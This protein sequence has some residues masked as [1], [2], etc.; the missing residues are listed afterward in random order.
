MADVTEETLPRCS[1]CGVEYEW[2]G[3][4]L[5]GSGCDMR[6]PLARIYI[7]LVQSWAR[8]LVRRLGGKG[9]TA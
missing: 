1:W 9:G 6:W 3:K 8:P 5:A 2:H 4:L 7:A